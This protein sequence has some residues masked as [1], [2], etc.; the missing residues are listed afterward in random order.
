MATAT[1]RARPPARA[2][3]SLDPGS[4]PTASPS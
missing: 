3:S 2:G 1:G 4:P